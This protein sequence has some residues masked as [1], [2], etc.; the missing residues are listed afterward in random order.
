MEARQL[1][2]A[3]QLVLSFGTHQQPLTFSSGAEYC[4][5]RDADCDFELVRPFASRHHARI[6]CRRQSF[7]LFDE[8]SN[9]TF[10]RNEDETVL[11]LHR[12][13]VRL[14][15]TGWLSFGEPLMA[16]SVVSFR[17]AG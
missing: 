12:R 2:S 1:V 17:H 4:I 7:W 14:W 13:G 8:S 5:G 15:G 6:V 3:T 16:D 9:G 11:Y 10:V